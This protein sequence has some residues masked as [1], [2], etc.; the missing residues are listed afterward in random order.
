VNT[1]NRLDCVAGRRC[2]VVGH[3]LASFAPRGTVLDLN[4]DVVLDLEP[5]LTDTQ[6]RALVPQMIA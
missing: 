5:G 6:I 2:P 1:D 3:A 4:D